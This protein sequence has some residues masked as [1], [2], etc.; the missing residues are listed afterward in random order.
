[1][2]R[3]SCGASITSMPPSY[4][5]ELGVAVHAAV[6]GGALIRA[7]ATTSTTHTF[8]EKR[9]AS[10]V[11][12]VDIA[13]EQAILAMLR[14]AFP[15]D[16]I[17]AEE[18]GQVGGASGRL[19]VI[20]PLDGTTNFAA[21]IPQFSVSIGLLVD[22]EPVVGVVH[23][24]MSYGL[25]TAVAGHGAT[26]SGRPIHAEQSTPRNPIVAIDVA[27]GSRAAATR[28]RAAL[29]GAT[30]RI[31]ENWS[32]ALDYVALA[33]RRIDAIVCMG[34]ESEDKYP[35]LL[36][37]LEAGCEIALLDEQFRPS[38]WQWRAFERYMPWFVVA[39]DRQTLAQIV[40][41]LANA[42]A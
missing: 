27:Y 6:T 29:D 39:T 8:E 4:S 22:H 24:P 28:A 42:P 32:P 12:E 21:G 11:S 7:A 40:A 14:A 5:H 20:D 9:D 16:G 13:S 3:A 1:M 15:D 38:P 18:S 30:S 33:T 41:Q 19:W 26:Y 25:A 2:R 34:A 37:A 36:I 31:F 10:I 17:Y 35:G 23:A